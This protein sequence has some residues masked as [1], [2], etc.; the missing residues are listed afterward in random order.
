MSI[1][2]SGTTRGNLLALQMVSDQI[3]TVQTRLATG[4][5]VNSVFDDPSAYF[6]SSSLSAR[7][8]SLNQ[9]V[10]NV[11][12]VKKSVDAANNGVQAITSLLNSAQSLATAALQSANTLVKVTGSNSTAL[13]TASV[14]A[15]SG[16]SATRLKAGDT[17]TVSDGTTTGTYTA[18]NGDTVQ[19]VLNAINGT[20]GLKVTAGLNS[21][22]Q[23]NFSATG[24]NN[25]TIGGVLTGPGTL[26]GVTGLTAGTTT[27]TANAIRTSYAAQFDALRTQID[28]AV[29]DASYNGIN[30]LAGGSKT[31]TLSETGA[32]TLTLSGSNISS[33]SLGVVASTNNFQLDSDITTVLANITS[34]LTTLQSQTST[35]GNSQAILDARTQFNKSMATTLQ[36]GSDELVKSN[37]TADGALLLALQTRQQLAA[38]SMSLT[39]GSDKLALRLLGFS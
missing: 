38:T 2:I 39:S 15:S 16:G 13:T 25:V 35:L 4:K 10:D 6:I 1:A 28:A 27:F 34:A 9:L 3:D 21:S 19:T 36:A 32:S 23:I 26:A 20:A 33:T 14:I 12:A 29:S 7:A 11:S 31:V 5:R 18:V 30:L 17:V 37:S 24:T 22:G 8:A